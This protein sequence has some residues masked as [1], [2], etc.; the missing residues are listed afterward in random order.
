[1]VDLH[2]LWPMIKLVS[3]QPYA[4]FQSDDGATI[5]RLAHDISINFLNIFD[6]IFI[7]FEMLKLIKSRGNFS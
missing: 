6:L 1:M 2:H 3:V 4:E 7:H 5:G